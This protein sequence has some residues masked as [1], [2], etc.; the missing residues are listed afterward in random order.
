MWR[1][2]SPGL[3]G[4]KKQNKKSLITGDGDG[5]Q[6]GMDSAFSAGEAPFPHRQAQTPPALAP[7][8][9]K[10]QHAHNTGHLKQDLTV[11]TGTGP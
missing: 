7:W 2:S 1:L 8:P 4:G 9:N 11:E 10:E 6:S 5:S 3:D